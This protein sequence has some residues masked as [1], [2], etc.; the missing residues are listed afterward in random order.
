MRN[1][2]L[3]TVAFVAL[4]AGAV[5][6][7]DEGSPGDEAIKEAI[8][9]LEARRAQAENKADR[10]KITKAIAAL[11]QLLPKGPEKKG[12]V[13]PP[14]KP[15][16]LAPADLAKKFKGRAAFNAKTAELTLLYD[17][18]SKEQLKDFELGGAAPTIKIRVV[19]VGPA[20]SIKHVV[21]FRRLKVTGEFVVETVQGG[22]GYVPFVRC[23]EG[24]SFGPSEFNGTSLNLYDGKKNLGGKG[25]AHNQIQGKPLSLTFTVT[26]KK[27]SAKVG[28]TEMA[29]PIEGGAAGHVEFLGGKGGLRIRS[30]VISGT[31]DEEWAKEFFK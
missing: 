30:L 1:L 26:E 28:T 19:R 9:I 8:T 13:K 18:K 4:A 10:E 27:A 22:T 15:L 14:A 25:F 5:L 29:G 11:D 23:S 21:K 31:L 20:D 24:V 3:T 17:F 6:G 2:I 16:K 12:A 7:Q